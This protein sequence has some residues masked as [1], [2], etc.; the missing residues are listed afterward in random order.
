M[1]FFSTLFRGG[2]VGVGDVGEEGRRG[3]GPFVAEE[4]R[5][6]SSFKNKATDLE[7]S[8]QVEKFVCVFFFTCTV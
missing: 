4:G 7:E 3:W 5:G 1:S 8:C 2:G 6:G